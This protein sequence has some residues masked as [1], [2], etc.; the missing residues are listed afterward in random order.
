MFFWKINLWNVWKMF[1]KKS[2]N[3]RSKNRDQKS[4]GQNP[5]EKGSAKKPSQ[6]LQ[7]IDSNFKTTTQKRGGTRSAPPRFLAAPIGAALLFWNLYRFFV[8][9]G[10]AFRP[11]FLLAGSLPPFFWRFLD[12]LFVFFWFPSKLF[13]W[14]LAETFFGEIAV[15]K[16]PKLLKKQL[17]A[18]YFQTTVQRIAKF[19]K[20]SWKIYFFC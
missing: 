11:S 18:I 2:S 9:V 19:F 4:G 8:G 13:R 1:G 12:R 6:V 15:Q 10:M 16:I 20:E 5:A 7:K 17:K 14:L 3:S